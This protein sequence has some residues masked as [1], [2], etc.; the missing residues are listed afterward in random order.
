MTDYQ[1]LCKRLTPRRMTKEEFE[2]L[3]RTFVFNYGDPDQEEREKIYRH[4][5]A[6]EKEVKGLRGHN[7]RLKRRLEESETRAEA[8]SRETEHLPSEAYSDDVETRRS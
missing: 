6:L 7:A 8:L 3:P 4:I 2:A 1:E 5:L